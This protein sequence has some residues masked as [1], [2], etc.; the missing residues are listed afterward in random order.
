MVVP[1]GLGGGICEYTTYWGGRG[2]RLP[3]PASQLRNLRFAQTL[4]NDA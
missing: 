1:G 3:G 2:M 4:Q